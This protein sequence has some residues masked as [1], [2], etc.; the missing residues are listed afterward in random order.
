MM[1]D[2]DS[3]KKRIHEAIENETDIAALWWVYMYVL[4]ILNNKELIHDVMEKEE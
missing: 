4:K 2:A 1:Q 3:V